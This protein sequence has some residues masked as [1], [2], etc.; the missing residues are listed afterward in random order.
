MAAKGNNVVDRKSMIGGENNFPVDAVPFPII[1]IA[2]QLQA[3]AVRAKAVKAQPGSA[4]FRD[5]HTLDGDIVKRFHRA[6]HCRRQFIGGD[7]HFLA[8]TFNPL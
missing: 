7:Y 2:I 5:P 8:E 6:G 1:N 4:V 3:F